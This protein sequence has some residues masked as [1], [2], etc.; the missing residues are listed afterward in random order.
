MKHRLDTG[1][2]GAITTTIVF[3]S[4]AFAA[5]R[6]GLRG[7]AP[8]HVA[9]LR[10]LVASAV[11]S[12]YAVA[13]RMPL[14]ERKDIPAIAALGFLGLTVYHVSL[15]YGEVTV[16]AGTASLIIASVP[17]FSA[18][19]AIA[20][21][22]ERLDAAGWVGIGLGFAGVALITVGRGQDVAFDPG[23]GLVLLSAVVSSIYVVFQK[24]LLRRY[25]A[26][27]F[28]TYTIWAGTFFMLVFLPGLPKAILTAPLGATLSIVYLG[29]FPAA[30][31]YVMLAYAISRTP[32]SIITSFLYMVPVLAVLIAWVW[33]GEIPARLSLIGGA[34][35]LAGVFIVNRRGSKPVSEPA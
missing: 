35:A 26:F 2:L 18:L 11:L 8:G 3:W 1:T 22:G 25:N 14:P 12:V 30:L 13:T 7:Y 17:V 6:A 33:L 19:L 15:S 27:Q 32:T 5:I 9:L 4:S 20:F 16:P 29:I 24:P 34:V 21:L 23:A 31:A 10:F 28:T